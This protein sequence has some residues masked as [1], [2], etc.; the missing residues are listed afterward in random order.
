[1]VVVIQGTTAEDEVAIIMEGL[2][3]VDMV[4]TIE[5]SEVKGDR[6]ILG[7]MVEVGLIC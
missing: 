3:Q 4:G 2:M 6:D 1:M 7:H 5:T